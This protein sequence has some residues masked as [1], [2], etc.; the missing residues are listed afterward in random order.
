MT[1]NYRLLAE[2]VRNRINPEHLAFQKRFSEELSTLSYSDV[3]VYVRLAMKGVDPDYTRRSKEAGERVKDHLNA[4]LNDVAFRYQGSVMTNTHIRAHSDIDLLTISN[5]FYSYDAHSAKKAVDE[6]IGSLSWSQLQKLRSEVDMSPYT[7]SPLEDLRL[8]RRDCENILKNKYSICD[9]S[10]AKAI[11][12]TN[13]SLGRDVD[14]VIANYY[15]DVMSI[16]HDKGEY[17]GIQVYNKDTHT[18]G[19]VDFPFLSIKRINDRGEETVGR[20]KKMIRFLKNIKAKSSVDIKLS[21]FDFNAICYD[22]T[23]DKYKNAKF[24]E[25]VP[26]IYQQVKSLC[27]DQRH[28]DALKSVD[29]REYIFRNNPAKLESLRSILNEVSGIYNDLIKSGVFGKVLV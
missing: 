2:S 14:I 16:L 24:Y 11:K 25:L 10:H 1:Q 4:S 27:D 7:G 9:I 28:A 23:V 17:R 19:M 18:R 15:D 26:V 29:G 6:Q 12:I 21:S 5:K 22:I 8:L 13:L 20:V 3:L